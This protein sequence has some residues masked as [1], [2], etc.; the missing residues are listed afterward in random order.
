MPSFQKRAG[1]GLGS[2]IIFITS[3]EYHFPDVSMKKQQKKTGVV[4]SAS[5]QF[6]MYLSL[7][8]GKELREQ[9][10]SERPIDM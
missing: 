5:N 6:L 10:H 1:D 9:S 8:I 3:T 7:A 4:Q 2:S